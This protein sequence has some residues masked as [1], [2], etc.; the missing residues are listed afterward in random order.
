M[1]LNFVGKSCSFVYPPALAVSD[2]DGERIH[3]LRLLRLT[4][5]SA[6]KPQLDKATLLP[7][8]VNRL[9]HEQDKLEPIIQCLLL[10]YIH[11]P[12]DAIDPNSLWYS[13]FCHRLF[14]QAILRDL[15]EPGLSR[16]VLDSAEMRRFRRKGLQVL[17]KYLRTAQTAANREFA[18]E[19]LRVIASQFKELDASAERSGL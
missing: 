19:A 18:K 1:V 9:F 8:L 11:C 3:Q 7:Q 13:R 14:A 2:P 5:Y 10:Y 6:P 12:S 4:L 16:A 17:Q 15:V